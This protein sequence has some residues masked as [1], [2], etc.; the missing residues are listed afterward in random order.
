MIQVA[1]HQELLNQLSGN[2]K[3]YLLLYKAEG[4][5][6]NRCAKDNLA[7]AE[8]EISG[9]TVFVA[10]VSKVRDIHANY[11]ID[12]V[13]ALL[14]FENR[15]YTRTIKGCHD[16]G[17]YKTLFNGTVFTAS[18]TGTDEK[19]QKNVVVYS[20]P[21]C[22]WCNTLKNYL[23]DN[24]IRFRDIDVSRDQKAAEEMVKRSGQ[25]GVPQTTINGE[26]IVGFDKGRIDRLL[27]IKMH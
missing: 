18:L 22:S 2:G 4:A 16:A 27:N 8:Q 23:K 12:S 20:T 10:D 14:E 3:S 6:Q 11:N 1:N 15:Q 21:T 9:A 17:Y 25:Q 13:P 26:V 19:P 24:N 5:D 7:L